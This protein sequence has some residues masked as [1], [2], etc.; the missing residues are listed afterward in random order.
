[1]RTRILA[2]K[3]ELKELA[4]TIRT[5]KKA[6]CAENH[7]FI[8]GLDTNQRNYRVKHVAYCL[9]RGRTMEQIE[10]KVREGNEL[11]KWELEIIAKIIAI[12]NAPE[13]VA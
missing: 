13:E 10:P 6:R 8:Y 7:G 5:M 4:S 11:S 2:L 1:M 12:V 3:K 9:A